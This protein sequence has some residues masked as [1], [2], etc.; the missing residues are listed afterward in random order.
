MI[1]RYMLIFIA[2]LLVN[3]GLAQRD[4]QSLLWKISSKEMKKPSYLFGTIHLICP[5][6][7]IW[8]PKMDESLQK[9]DEV[10]FEMDMD[11]PNLMMIIAQGL[12]ETSGKKLSDYFTPGQYDSLSRYFRTK[13]G[14]DIAMFEQM[15]P[16]ALQTL[17]ISGFTSCE[18]P[19]AYE[20]TIMEAAQ[21]TKKNITGLEEPQEQLAL[22]DLLMTDTI[23][24]DIMNMIDENPDEKEEYYK[25]VLA[26]KNQDLKSLHNIIETSKSVG[27][28]MGELIDARNAR[29][30]GRMIGKMDQGP[31]F[32][33]VGAGHLPGDNGIINLLRKEGYEV[34]AIK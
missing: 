19:I 21:K 24:K 28:E 32:F 1:K 25:M 4:E 17:M 33:A 12:M 18:Q 20:S 10:C 8:S 22:L 31:V 15:K 13:L 7:Y 3:T 30:I 2:L 6:D 26:Y 23:A 29:W 5:E 11:D 9:T 34:E 14:M 16:Q 27:M